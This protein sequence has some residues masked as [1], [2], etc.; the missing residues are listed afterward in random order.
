MP[1]RELEKSALDERHASPNSYG[2]ANPVLQK[3]FVIFFVQLFL[4]IL[5]SF[6]EQ[7]GPVFVYRYFFGLDFHDFYLGAS[8]LFHHL[9]P[10]I[11]GRLFTPPSSILIGIALFHLPFKIATLIVF[12]INIGLIFASL[13]ALARQFGLTQSNRLALLGVAATFYPVYFVVE[14]G[15]LDGITFARDTGGLVHAFD[16]AD[17]FRPG[18]GFQVFPHG[19]LG[20]G[21]E[22]G[23]FLIDVHY[24]DPAFPECSEPRMLCS[25]PA[26]KTAIPTD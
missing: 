5:V 16:G 9:D 15:N 24:N 2:P 14:R 22:G 12:V 11:R 10:Y 21:V 13:L 3:L 4:L 7:G 25:R 19:G 1:T 18:S 17:F 8:D 6:V 20:A 26:G 23:L